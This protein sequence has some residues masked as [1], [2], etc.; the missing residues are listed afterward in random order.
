MLSH[1]AKSGMVFSA[2]K[3]VFGA[4]EVEY[5]G[6]LVGEDSIQPTPKY[7]QNILS[8]PTPKNISDIRSWFGLVN[9][10]AYA[11]S[12]GTI[13]APFRELL[14]PDGKFEW[15]A[16]MNEAFEKSK[17]EIVRLVKDG[18]K[19]FDPKLVTCLSTDFCKTGL[20]WIL[21]QK[22]CRCPVISP[23]CCSDGWRLVLAGGRFTIPAESRYSPVEGEALAV[24]TGLESSR[25]YTLGC[26]Q[27]Y[28]AT[29]HK[30][31]LAILNDRAMD[32]IVNPR[33]LRLKERTLPWKFDMVY[34]PGNRQ[35]A[36]D[37]LSRKKSVGVL[38]SLSVCA[39]KQADMEDQLQADM[40][41]SLMELSVIKTE[42]NTP[43]VELEIMS[44][45]AQPSV[46]TWSRLQDA[47]REDKILTKLMEMIQRGCLTAATS[48]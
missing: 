39:M 44:V 22:V 40:G 32:T 21:Q 24:A 26:R 3:F 8:F 10:V 34:V 2:S 17:V 38:A 46:I 43:E 47:T 5:A 11:F 16:D 33:L 30:P 25:Y 27:L 9:Q 20:G 36:A 48:C 14:K 7:L 35:A 6:F 18:V 1:C 31:L 13:M 45:E 15:T 28:V 19:M 37:T 41:V 12:K 42:N 4:K 29:D 23:V